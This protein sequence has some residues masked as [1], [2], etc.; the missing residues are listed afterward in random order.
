M[1]KSRKKKPKAF[2]KKSDSTTSPTKKKKIS[3]MSIGI[4]LG[5]VLAAV[6]LIYISDY[7][8]KPKKTNARTYIP[9]F[10]KEGELTFFKGNSNEEIKTIDIEIAEDNYE[11]AQGLMYRVSMGDSVGMFFIMEQEKPQSFWMRN[12]YI[13]LDIIYLDKELNI[14]KI[15]KYTE[16]LSEESIPSIRKAKFVVEVIAGFCDKYLIEEGDYIEYKREFHNKKT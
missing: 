9:K 7:D 2:V 4:I 16:P 15:Q 10:K 5:I 3:W 13:S 11:R 12:T 8:R 1:T 14:V 6:I